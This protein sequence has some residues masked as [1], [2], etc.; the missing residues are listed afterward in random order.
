MS[1]DIWVII[2]AAGVGK[3]M[4]AAIPKQ[5]LSLNGRMVLEHT[6]RLFINQPKIAGVVVVISEGDEYWPQVAVQLGSMTQILHLV[7]GGQERA[8]SV[9][10][11][12]NYLLDTLSLPGDTVVLV[13][14]AARPCLPA[15]DL[16]ALLACATSL[17][18]QGVLLATPVRDTMKRSDSVAGINR[19]CRTE[20]RDGLWHA[21]TPQMALLGVL[22]Q[23]LQTA[24]QQGLS[25]TDEASA[26]ELMGLQP[27]LLEGDASNIKITRPTDLALADFFLQQNH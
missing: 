16:Q 2:P 12:L 10:N 14:D 27:R 21:L 5:Y 4:Q 25:V 18:E 11:G 23:A 9:L 22:R 3:R 1:N 6:L 19:V 17:D 8:N 7:S 15:G 20:E 26:L 24:L 13:H